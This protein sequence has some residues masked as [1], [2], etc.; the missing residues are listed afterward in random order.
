MSSPSNASRPE[1]RLAAIM[2]ADVA[3]YSRL[4]GI[5]ESGT[6]DALNAHLSELL[7]P[8]IAADGGR[9]VKTAGDGLL[10]EFGSVVAAVRCA[11][12][13]QRGMVARNATVADDR[14]LDFRI[15]I[16]LGD[17]IV[18]AGDIFGDGVNVAARL[19]G[20]AAPGGIVVSRSVLETTRKAVPFD[21]V[22]LGPQ[23]FHNIA[24]AVHAYGLRL[25]PAALAA[26]PAAADPWGKQK[27]AI[28]VL[29]FDSMGGDREQQYF[30]DGV[31]EDIITALAHFRELFVIARNSTFAHRDRPVDVRDVA[32]RLGVRYVVEGSFRRI[33]TR[34]RITAQL[35]DCSSGAHLWADRFDAPVAEIF[36]LQDHITDQIVARIA[37]QV[38]AAEIERA[39]RKH[40]ENLDAYDLYLRGL[41]YRD[42]LTREALREAIAHFRK[43]IELEPAYA[44]ALAHAATCLTALRDQGWQSLSPA[45][46]AEAVELSEA[47]VAADPE[48]AVALC[49][50][51]QVIAALLGDLDRGLAWIDRALAINPN[52]A[53]AWSRSSMVRIYAGDLSTASAHAD[54]AMALSPL[55]PAIF[56]PLCAK[57]YSR[58][59]MR[60]FAAAVGLARKALQGKQKPPMAYRIMVTGLAALGDEAG[61]AD[62]RAALL[63]RDPDFRISAWR[64]R[65]PFVRPEQVALL[66]EGFRR[67]GLTE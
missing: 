57:A 12:D 24:E 17:V 47:A 10:A 8:K 39:R 34:V 1:R 43:A 5:D 2:V 61:L 51:G 3:G 52:H 36:D 63:R 28:A 38:R 62:A 32:R 15:G 44:A 55:D 54:R 25:P 41:A 59:F 13:V 14:R 4:M 42:T 9:L 29:P 7:L 23:R 22:D 16:N 30:A 56:L 67:A 65:T 40:P 27:P 19:Q 64:T 60:D 48:D 46:T 26:A 18:V 49:L 66:V 33:A 37:P 21:A 31:V 6:L 58:L 35:I 53:D 11:L 20:L 50:S 45:E